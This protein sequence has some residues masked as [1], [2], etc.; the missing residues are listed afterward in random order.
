MQPKIREGTHHL[1]ANSYV[2]IGHGSETF[3]AFETRAATH[4]RSGSRRAEFR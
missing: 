2:G 4:N 1:E 3:S